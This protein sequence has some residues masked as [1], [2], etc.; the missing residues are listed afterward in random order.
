MK[1][2][3]SG[4]SGFLGGHLFNYFNKQGY[5]L[6]A[7]KRSDFSKDAAALAEKIEGSAVVIH[8][9]GAPIA[10]RWTVKHKQQIYDSR[11]LTTRKLVD[12]LQQMS[13]PPD[14]FICA[15]AVGIYADEGLHGESSTGFSDGF[16]GRVCFDWEAEAARAKPLCRT[17]MF[18]FGIILGRDGGALQQMALPFK[19]G[20]GGRI[21]S[22]KQTMSWIHIDDVAGIV[23]FAISHP[24]L[25]GPVNICAPEAVS[26]LTF[27]K[28][29]AKAL[30]RPAIFR[31]PAFMLK[32][33]FG[34][35]A[36]VLTGG[37]AARPDKLQEH[38]YRFRH[39]ALDEA[40][41]HIFRKR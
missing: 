36:V 37:Q 4:A 35:G 18:R 24:G 26:N 13:A 7:L 16:L 5:E 15:S 41:Q 19:V 21:A 25:N 38:G 23:A 39:P 30:R 9:A 8:L 17:L 34:Q 3:I 27:T 6:I 28:A 32:L 29:L 11:I 12:A 10:K 31:V 40:L 22:G 2:S 33:V 1:I 14:C 20:L